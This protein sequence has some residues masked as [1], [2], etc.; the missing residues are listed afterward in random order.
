VELRAG[1]RVDE[2]YEVVEVLGRG[3][4]AV[5]YAVRH[6]Q[7]GTTHALKV[8]Q[9]PTR[10][11]QQRLIVEGQIQGRLRHPNVVAVTDTVEV[12]GCPG[13]VL[14]LVRGPPLDR[15]LREVPLELPQLR[16]LG[17]QVLLGMQAAHR[18]GHVHR[19]LK[20]ANVLI[21]VA[22]VALVAKVAD[23]GLAKLLLPDELGSTA[24]RTGTTLGTP[25]YM[26]PEQLRD[27]RSVD[28]RADVFSLGALLYELVTS[29]RAFPGDDVME[30]FDAIR[31]GRFTPAH[32]VRPDLPEGLS[33]AISA[34]LHPDP[35][36]RTPSVDALLDG[37]TGGAG[38]D[39]AQARW[40]PE[41]VSRASELGV[42]V[43]R[44]RTGAS[45]SS[46]YGV[47]TSVADPPR[48]EVRWEATV[49]GA[50]VRPGLLALG[51]TV[52][53]ATAALVVAGVVLLVGL[54]GVGVVAWRRAPITRPPEVVVVE[55]EP[56]PTA[57]ADVRAGR[58][59]S[60][61]S[62]RAALG[63]AD[64]ST[65]ACADAEPCLEL[66]AAL[67]WADDERAWTWIEVAAAQGRRSQRGKLARRLA[68][69]AR[70]GA[71][72]TTGGR[73][74]DQRVDDALALSVLALMPALDPDLRRREVEEYLEAHPDELGPHLLLARLA[75]RAGTPA[76]AL[77]HVEEVLAREPGHPLALVTRA[78]L[79]LDAGD[80]ERALQLCE[81]VGDPQL[82]ARVRAG[83]L[84]T[85][86]RPIPA[87]PPGAEVAW[88]LG[89]AEGAFGLGFVSE[90]TE[91]VATAWEG[92]DP[93]GRGP[94]AWLLGELALVA[95]RPEVLR[96]ASL[97][98]RKLAGERLAPLESARLVNRADLLDGIAALHAGRPE[99]VA[100]A[101]KGLAGRAGGERTARVLTAVEQASR[102][103]EPEGAAGG[104]CVF[105][106][107]QARALDA[108]G[109][110][111][112]APLW[113]ALATGDGRCGAF[114]V[115]RLARAEAWLRYGA[116]RLAD[117]DGAA[118]KAAL[119]EY[120]LLV[121]GIDHGLV[122]RAGRLGDD[123]AEWTTSRAGAP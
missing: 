49:P 17:T 119:D 53:M 81:Q 51:A 39:A 111:R 38:A 78:E 52:S 13:L 32:E 23:F 77:R 55:R 85:L 68:D 112:A 21:D 50:S 113:Y 114:G 66:A 110:A 72:A 31:A 89:L 24:T 118:A 43:S 96:D 44:A 100:E 65:E 48:A 28:E 86:D 40:W 108:A 58:W 97:G 59:D 117:G 69:L 92:S 105:R 57:S 104:A 29:R 106:V 90:A 74:L 107:A 87:P 41:Q 99:G 120:Y 33:L 67:L 16:A 27:A 7:L 35:A 80:F 82:T 98:L 25:A 121:T 12:D 62:A 93:L 19:D 11:I 103:V 76:V 56:T 1:T 15:L 75:G 42:A 3:A 2:R 6:L 14:E 54:V 10:A 8:L 115:D 36:A 84:R 73:L 64:E 63:P 94:S 18:A 95:D 71:D 37:W 70:A 79:A 123:L 88:S 61:A 5:V 34:A 101:H 109:S 91:H 4:M 22:D 122:S 45:A 46:T 83:A 20:P 47:G 26:A 116:L 102:G 9:L 60:V 30:V